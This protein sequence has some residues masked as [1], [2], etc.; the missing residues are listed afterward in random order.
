[1]FIICFGVNLINDHNV[2]CRR[3]VADTDYEDILAAECEGINYQTP[4]YE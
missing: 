3:F 1:M 4:V 2:G